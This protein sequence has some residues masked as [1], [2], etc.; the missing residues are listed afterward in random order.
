MDKFIKYILYGL[1]TFFLIQ[2]FVCFYYSFKVNDG[3][4]MLLSITW[5]SIIHW[6]YSNIKNDY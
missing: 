3:K 5:I 4:L 1:N 6:N 2:S